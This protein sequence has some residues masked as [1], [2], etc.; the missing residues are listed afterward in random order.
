M[1]CLS[2]LSYMEVKT[3]AFGSIYSS[4]NSLRM[5]IIMLLFYMVQRQPINPER[6]KRDY[7]RT[8]ILLKGGKFHKDQRHDRD[9]FQDLTGNAT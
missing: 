9:C 1:G 3:V 7:T 2:E 4:I 5:A 6:M 8:E